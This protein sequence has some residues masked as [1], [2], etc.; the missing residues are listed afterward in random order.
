M[1]PSKG[2]IVKFTDDMLIN[3]PYNWTGALKGVDLDVVNVKLETMMPQAIYSVFFMVNGFM[4][5]IRVIITGELIDDSGSIHHVIVFKDAFASNTIGYAPVPHAPRAISAPAWMPGTPP[6]PK[7][8]PSEDDRCKKCGT[9]GV[10]MGM[11]CTC[12]SCGNTIWGA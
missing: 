3:S 8:G 10:V 1:F 4:N 6:Q 5:K 12:P 7:I 2:D 9:M 11:C